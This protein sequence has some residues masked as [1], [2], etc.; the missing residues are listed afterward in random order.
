MSQKEWLCCK[1]VASRI[2]ITVRTLYN[3]KKRNYGP[4]A[5]DYGTI[6][7]YRASD[8]ADW[9]QQLNNQAA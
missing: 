5:Y 3:W 1:E 9:Q 2:G 8:I 4:K 6:T 7:R